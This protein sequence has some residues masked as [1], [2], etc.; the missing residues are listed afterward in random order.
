MEA[1]DVHG[2]AAACA[3]DDDNDGQV[4]EKAFAWDEKDSPGSMQFTGEA[5]TKWMQ[6]CLGSRDRRIVTLL[7]MEAAVLRRRGIDDACLIKRLAKSFST[8]VASLGRLHKLIR[9]KCSKLTLFA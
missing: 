1:G 2:A 3:W 7:L 6:A 8:T 4:V 9:F 5:E